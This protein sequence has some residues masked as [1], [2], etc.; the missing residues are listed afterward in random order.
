[1]A[2]SL[3]EKR[4]ILTDILESYDHWA[5]AYSGGIDSSFLLWFITTRTS[6]KATSFFVNHE[7]LP[8]EVLESAEEFTEFLKKSSLNLNVS[9]IQMSLLSIE[10]I[11]RNQRDRCYHCKNHMFRRIR[12]NMFRH[13]CDALCDGTI[14]D[15]TF[16]DRP[17]SKALK[18]VG[19]MSPLKMAGFTKKE[20]VSIVAEEI[21]FVSNL[22]FRYESCLATRF[23]YDYEINLELLKEIDAIET[24]LKKGIPGPVRARYEPG[25][26]TIRLEIKSCYLPDFF[27]RVDVRKVLKLVRELGF[28][29]VV[30]DLAGYGAR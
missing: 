1:M 21:P 25:R 10:Q 11:K 2:N 14:S 27:K 17:G 7:M 30:L 23:P 8:S 24:L 13:G 4:K 3:K 6:K 15:D 18:E 22:W 29:D 26:G 12:D 9:A 19:V 5:V 28:S 16:E 20:I